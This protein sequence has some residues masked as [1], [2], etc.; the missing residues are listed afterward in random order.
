[1]CVPELRLLFRVHFDGQLG[2]LMNNRGEQLD[3]GA[4]LL[5][6]SRLPGRI[7]T[8]QVA[9]LLGIAEHDVPILTSAGMLHPLG[10]PAPSSPKWF[11]AIEIIFLAADRAWMD[12]ASKTLSQ[13]WKRKRLRKRSSLSSSDRI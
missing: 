4:R 5:M 6:E 2:T 1:M 12:K 13:H 9:K 8:T 11:S 7:D 3:A 10:S